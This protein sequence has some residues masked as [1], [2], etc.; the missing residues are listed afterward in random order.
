[1]ANQWRAVFTEWVLL[2]AS[3]G[4]LFAVDQLF[5]VACAALSIKFPSA[6]LGMSVLLGILLALSWQS[7][8]AAERMYN[9]FS[10]ALSFI[11]HYM[12]MFY[13]PLLVTLPQNTS[14]LIGPLLPRI[15]LLLVCGVAA[16]I[17]VTGH[18]VTIIRKQT[19]Q[20][21]NVEFASSAPTSTKALRKW[22]SQ[23]AEVPLPH[24][25]V[26]RQSAAASLTGHLH[27]SV[28][29]SCWGCTAVLSGA[30]S[31]A[32]ST[33]GS[34]LP[35]S[36]CRSL[37]T[38][39]ATIAS[40]AG[41]MAAPL[42]FAR[43]GA[44]CLGDLHPI[45]Y[46]GAGTHLAAVLLALSGGPTHAAIFAEYVAPGGGGALLL[47]FLRVIILTFGFR[48]F[49]QR[50]LIMKHAPEVVGGIA[51]SVW[52]SLLSTAIGGRLLNLPPDI[53]R[54]IIPRSVTAAL[55][56]PIAESLGAQLSTTA[57]AIVCTGM[58]GAAMARPLL[59]CAGITDPLARGI[60][61]A[62]SAHG[63]ATA[64]LGTAEPETL[65][66]AALG[67]CLT[68]VFAT[69]VCQLAPVRQLLIG[70]TG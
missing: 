61:A 34:Q 26:A 37:A 59:T 55:G 35:G 43:W 16:S 21:G 2:A 19:M 6:L 38:L 58:M 49:E 57:A 18:A 45:V 51:L 62:A 66:F 48:L 53:A 60:A 1:M 11:H 67:Y 22:P 15:I 52:F 10:P 29:A 68:G 25:D 40:Y 24:G 47:K 50:R 54:A 39:S 7:E 31:L 14:S 17:V 3:L 41:G 32:V 27:A 63:M 30:A 44:D 33:A 65:P 13:A 69:A 12:A 42:L 23:D 64:A 4:A 36:Y 28:I 9:F 56:L 20:G 5:K 70:I 8:A 46:C